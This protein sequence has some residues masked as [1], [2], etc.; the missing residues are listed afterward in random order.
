MKNIV[1]SLWPVGLALTAT[2][3]VVKFQF[4]QKT[5]GIENANRIETNDVAIC[6]SSAGTI[7]ADEDGKFISVLPGWGNLHYKISSANDSAQFYFNQGLSFYYGY[8]FTESLAS[9]KEASRFD[10]SNAM[11]YWGQA[12]AMGPFYNTYVYKMRKE[13]PAVVA[14]MKLYS[15][16]ATAKEKVLI[17]AIDQRY[18][19]D[20]TNADRQKLNR[21]YALALAAASKKFPDDHDIKALYVDAVM[22]EH[23]WDFWSND[24]VARPWTQELISVCEAGLKTDANHPA[25]LHYYIHLVEASR[26]PQR[27]L[28]AADALKDNLPGV[29]H[30]VHMSS[31]MYQRNGLYAKGVKV[32]EDASAVS[33]SVDSRA[34][35]LNL[36]KNKSIHYYAVQSYCA[37]TAGMDTKGAPL[38][39]RARERQVAMAPAFEK[40]AYAQFIYMIPVTAAV[41]LGKWDAILGAPQPNPSWKYALA[42]DNFAKGVAHIHAKNIPEAKK[43]LAALNAV[44][45]DS[46]L[47]VR[48]MPFNSPV[49]SCRVASGIL[50]GQLLYA[51][52]KTQA[53]IVAFTKAVAEEDQMIYREPH[54]WM[55]PARQ[56]LG[57]YLLKMNK[58]AE[59]AKIFQEDLIA[60]PGNGWSLLGMQQSLEAQKKTKEAADYRQKATKA[61]EAAD[62]LPTTPVFL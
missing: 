29:P 12:L 38:Y 32:N 45:G 18:S 40:D 62:A 2:L 34:P 42:L 23:K 36:G 39:D 10:P 1:F 5:V 16:T 8:H 46:L 4:S 52:G 33:N 19:N 31:H 41:R 27:A 15:S 53:S 37:M 17:E 54:D 50:N 7:T 20:L 13:V 30:M 48:L 49:Q 6:A 60:N 43:C 21:D 57:T 55:I 61:F 58:P 47:G 44:L 22:L 51:E 56:Y 3:A 35:Q 24:G 28:S 25:F 11:V 9:F 14:S 59:A 26:T